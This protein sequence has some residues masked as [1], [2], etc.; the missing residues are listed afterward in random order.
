MA[1][2]GVGSTSSFGYITGNQMPSSWELR[3]QSQSLLVSSL[4]SSPSLASS[5][6]GGNLDIYS[7]VSQQGMG[8]LSSGSRTAMEIAN[9][10][11]GIDMSQKPHY[12][13]DKADATDETDATPAK[14][15]EKPK[16]APM[17]IFD[18]VLKESGYV[19]PADDPYVYQVD[20]F[21][22]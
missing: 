11:L 16:E 7:A 21:A 13:E 14:E 3:A 9:I 19:K 6:L 1:I 4:Q 12:G 2:D 8:L 5:G 18:K 10:S 22:S 20:F 17:S 15:V